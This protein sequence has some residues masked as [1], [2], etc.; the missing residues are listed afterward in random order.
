M[1]KFFGK[2]GYATTVEKI[3]NG[4]PT[5]VWVDMI[6][7]MNYYGDVL[8]TSTRW[9]SRDQVNDDLTVS[10]KISILADG[11]AI[12][13]F[14]KIK[15]IVWNGV[16]WKVTNITVQRPRIILTL[17]GEYNGPTPRPSC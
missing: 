16:R 5:G 9:Q 7:E 12:Q 6:K 4:M 2:V 3:T 13:N 14:S 15:Y 8:D 1:G 11:Y 10:N 17:G